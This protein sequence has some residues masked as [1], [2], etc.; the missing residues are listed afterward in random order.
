MIRATTNSK[1]DH[2]NN[3]A[4][5]D[6]WPTQSSLPDQLSEHTN[7]HISNVPTIVFRFVS[8]DVSLQ[9]QVVSLVTKLEEL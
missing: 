8:C 1:L 3:E 5:Q 9:I 4:R 2:G 7:I 6:H